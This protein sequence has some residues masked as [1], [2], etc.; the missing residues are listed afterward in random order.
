MP[1]VSA[2]QHRFMEAAAHNP[3]FAKRAGISQ[4]TAK[5][6][7]MKDKAKGNPFAKAAQTAMATP[8]KKK[9]KGKGMKIYQK[10]AKA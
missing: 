7:V 8:P 1:S 5:E 6:F 4:S 2:K 3:A 9:G 10:G